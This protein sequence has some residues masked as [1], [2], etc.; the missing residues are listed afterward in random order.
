MWVSLS[1]TNDTALRR[2]SAVVF[3]DFV[4]QVVVPEEE[5]KLTQIRIREGDL[6]EQQVCGL[7]L[8]PNLYRK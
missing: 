6:R 1:R 8:V 4:Y 5:E 7:V 2:T 3:I